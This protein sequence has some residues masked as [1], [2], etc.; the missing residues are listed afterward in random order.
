MKY[1][2][3]KLSDL[4]KVF[5]KEIKKFPLT[6]ITIIIISIIFS[7]TYDTKIL[8]STVIENI[9]LFGFIFAPSSFLIETIYNK[10]LSKKSILYI[11]SFII[12]IILVYLANIKTTFLGIPNNIF[13]NY[14]IRL[15][16]CY[17]ISTTILCIYYNYKNRSEKFNKYI[18]YVFSNLFKSTIIYII[19]SIGLS[20]ITSIFISLILENYN[21]TLIMR[22]ES[23]LFGCY[24]IPMII[25][26]LTDTN[27]EISK[28]SKIVIKYVLES[29]LIIAFLIIYIYI[30][31]IIILRKI[32]SNEIF[33]ILSLLFIFGCPI[34][35]MISS[36]KKEK[37]LY[38]INNK[39]PILFIPFILLQI[40]SLG[41]RILNNGITEIRYIGLI[42]IIIEIIYII[43]FIINKE[44]L[45]IMLPIIV[46]FVIVSLLFPYINMYKISQL[47]QY[48]NLK[49]YKEKEI[50]TKKDKAKIYGAYKYL[51]KSITKDKYINKLL[52]KKDI[53]N[54]L[55]FN[56]IKTNKPINIYA[57]VNINQI[58]V[59]NYSKLYLVTSYNLYK[60][61]PELTFKDLKNTTVYTKNDNINF[62]IDLSEKIK[63]Y[64]NNREN[65]HNYL[66][67]HNV[68][69]TKSS[70]FI[71]RNLS[72]IYNKTKNK[73]QRYRIEGYYLVK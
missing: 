63:D 71:I 24:Y 52:T 29:L 31:K 9:I 19:L 25:K 64:I 27:Q 28:F 8:K 35:T 66:K 45:S 43:I 37:I 67:E 53:E 70:K 40:Y 15:I 55:E 42:L 57:T 59:E 72:I 58:N 46:A 22:V 30:F 65:I 11:L 10:S 33:R 44:K 60:S 14:I 61:N 26:S 41:I 73:I 16:V 23:L 18:T 4:Y 48:N 47:S 6:I 36:F 1:L 2:K 50:L 51:N 69:E 68:V 38:K 7:I 12:S 56:S 21:T 49:I 20:I 3:Q 17:I 39:L 13:I 54:I 62:E 34:W 32:P 5:R